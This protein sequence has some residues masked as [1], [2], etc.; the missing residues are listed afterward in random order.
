[1]GNLKEEFSKYQIFYWVDNDLAPF[2]TN[3]FPSKSIFGIA[4]RR[5]N[6]N[7]FY[8]SWVGEI[9]FKEE[10]SLSKSKEQGIYCEYITPLLHSK[11]LVTLKK[12]FPD[13]PIPDAPSHDTHLHS[14]LELI[15]KGNE[16]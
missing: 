4:F 6:G 16:E 9:I 15:L 3:K 10:S 2:I 14:T 8:R 1:M 13:I 7:L 12:Y 5:S 11:L